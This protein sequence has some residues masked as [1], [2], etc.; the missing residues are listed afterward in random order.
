MRIGFITRFHY[1]EN[2]PRFAWR[3]AYYKDTVLPRVLAQQGEFDIAIRCNPAHDEIFKAL[4]PRIR[5]FHVKGEAA[6][7]KVTSGRRYFFDFV[8][9]S[10]VIDL[11]RYDL[12]LGLDSDDLIESNYLE[13]VLKTLRGMPTHETTHISFQPELLDVKTGKI[14]R[15][16]QKYSSTKGSAFFALYHPP[17]TEPYRFAYEESHLTIGRHFTNKI[18][19]PEGICF[20]SCHDI[21]ESTHI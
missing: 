15:M 13:W 3:F 1:E 12:Q 9:W 6:R 16:P 19:M 7:Y 4:S 14:H 17:R 21:N 11:P 8:P 2:D 10:D 20:A 5:V 18:V